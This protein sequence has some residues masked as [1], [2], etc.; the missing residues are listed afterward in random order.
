[1]RTGS[2]RGIAG[3]DGP[4]F[5]YAR[6]LN[7]QLLATKPRVSCRVN[8]RFAGNKAIAGASSLDIASTVAVIFAAAA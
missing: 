6:Y 7:A 5:R 1:M 3:R 8:H 2:R 4:P